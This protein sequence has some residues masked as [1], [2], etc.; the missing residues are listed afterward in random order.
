MPGARTGGGKLVVYTSEGNNYQGAHLARR[1][2]T[3]L[4]TAVNSSLNEQRWALVLSTAAGS[5]HSLG[6]LRRWRQ[7]TAF[8]RQGA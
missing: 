2:A 6:A 4:G 3:D 1:F 8:G 7:T 5:E